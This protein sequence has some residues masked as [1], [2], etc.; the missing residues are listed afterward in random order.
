[1]FGPNI[2]K[3][4]KH[5]LATLAVLTPHFWVIYFGKNNKQV[6]WSFYTCEILILP[7]SS[8]LNISAC[9]I[10]FF[11]FQISIKGFEQVL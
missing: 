1:M 7:Q 6:K 9:K 8:N 4:K 5:F 11:F 10:G 2:L 3:K